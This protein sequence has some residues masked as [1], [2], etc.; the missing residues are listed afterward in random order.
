MRHRS[1]RRVSRCR[2]NRVA[3]LRCNPVPGHIRQSLPAGGFQ[4]KETRLVSHKG[5]LQVWD[6]TS[7]DMIHSVPIPKN[8]LTAEFTRSIVA[9]GKENGYHIPTKPHAF[10]QYNPTLDTRD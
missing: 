3:R 9:W 4:V 2:S 10:N 1:D 7:L 5:R 6:V 8:G